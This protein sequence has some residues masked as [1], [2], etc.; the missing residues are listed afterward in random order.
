MSREHFVAL[1][2]AVSRIDDITCAQIGSWGRHLAA[3][4]AG[5]GRLH[6]CGNAGSAAEV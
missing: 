4:L 6:A 5:G 3:V 1:R 2:I